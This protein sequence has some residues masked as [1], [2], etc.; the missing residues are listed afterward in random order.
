MTNGQKLRWH[1]L[2]QDYW[3]DVCSMVCADSSHESSWVSEIQDQLSYIPFVCDSD[4][5]RI[6]ISTRMISPTED[7]VLSVCLIR[8]IDETW[9]DGNGYYHIALLARSWSCHGT[10]MGFFAVRNALKFIRGNSLETGRVPIVTAYMDYRNDPS[11]R[12]FE[13]FGFSGEGMDG[14]YRMLSVDLGRTADSSGG[15][16]T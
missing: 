15:C 11:L 8:I 12:L 1:D 4:T 9:S 10:R 6:R 3:G 16:N 13:S 14:R 5:D 7:E 2:T